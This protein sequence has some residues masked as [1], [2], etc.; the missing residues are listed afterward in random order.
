MDGISGEWR[1]ESEFDGGETGCGELLLDLRNH[2]RALPARH[3]VVVRA[4]GAGAPIEIP[5]WC[6]MTGHRLIE[7]G[8]P[9]YLIQVREP[10]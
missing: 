8:H 10:S 1:C 7:S 9:F 3:R 6:R 5:A 4:A 2:F